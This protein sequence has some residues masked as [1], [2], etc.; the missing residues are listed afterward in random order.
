MAQTDT[1]PNLALEQSSDIR[2]PASKKKSCWLLLLAIPVYLVALAAVAGLV[3]F[4]WWALPSAQKPQPQAQFDSLHPQLDVTPLVDLEIPADMDLSD[5]AYPGVLMTNYGGLQLDMRRYTSLADASFEFPDD[6][7]ELGSW[8]EY[9]QADPAFGTRYALSTVHETSDYGR[10]LGSFYSNLYIQKGDVLIH[11][12]EVTSQ[13]DS[14]AK[15]KAIDWLAGELSGQIQSGTYRRQTPGY[16]VFLPYCIDCHSTWGFGAEAP[17]SPPESFYASG[18]GPSLLGLY[19]SQVQ[20]SDSTQVTADEE[21]LLRS[22][23]Q[24]SA[25]IVAGYPS[26]QMVHFT[27]LS[28]RDIEELVAYIISLK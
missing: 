21:Y 4:I 14:L 3:Y 6:D 13:K 8:T 16:F 15:Q 25:Q 5:W 23:D 17:V 10:G 2:K 11:F 1:N 22:I 24:P 12:S 18:T 28:D 7:P 27:Q 20:L 9:V 19:G 26:D